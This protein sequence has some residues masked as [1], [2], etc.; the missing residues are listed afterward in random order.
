MHSTGS[1]ARFALSRF[2]GFA[3]EKKRRK[4]NSQMEPQSSNGR[5][6]VDDV[7]V[8]QNVQHHAMPAVPDLDVP[9]LDVPNLGEITSTFEPITDAVPPSA[10]TASAASTAP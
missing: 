5:D 10:S 2:V 8:R 9:S 7:A 4:A 3:M 1:G 6:G